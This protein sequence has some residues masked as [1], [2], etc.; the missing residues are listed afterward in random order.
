[1]LADWPPS[2]A[3]KGSRAHWVRCCVKP[4]LPRAARREGFA[5]PRR[6][7]AALLPARDL[8]RPSGPVPVLPVLLELCDLGHTAVRHT[9]GA[10]PGRVACPTLQSLEP[11]R[12]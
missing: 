7:T 10:G 4:A 9:E 2:R 8:S 3:R 12:R 1:M 5:E 6:G 11:R